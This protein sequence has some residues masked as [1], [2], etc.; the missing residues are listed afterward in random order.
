[1][2]GDG[3]GVGGVRVNLG[4]KQDSESLSPRLFAHLPAPPFPALFS[5]LGHPGK[6]VARVSTVSLGWYKTRVLVLHLPFPAFSGAVSTLSML[7]GHP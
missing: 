3:K 6:P 1:M 7:L 5:M 4:L 2:L